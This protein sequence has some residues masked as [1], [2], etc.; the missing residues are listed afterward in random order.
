MSRTIVNDEI[1][2]WRD[3]CPLRLWMNDQPRGDVLRQLMDAAGVGSHQ[4]VY[5][6]LHGHY[7]PVRRKL[8]VIQALTGIDPVKWFE[9]FM[10][11]PHQEVESCAVTETQSS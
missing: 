3:R 2:A 5:G 8:V 6:W 9:W 7:M 10:Q 4:T 1:Q 11:R